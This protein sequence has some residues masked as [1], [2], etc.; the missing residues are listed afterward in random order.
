M[1]IET[2]QSD[3]QPLNRANSCATL[4]VRHSPCPLA[5]G[6]RRAISPRDSCENGG[7]QVSPCRR[8]A[9]SRIGSAES[10]H[11]ATF[12]SNPTLT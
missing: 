5:V 12:L 4:P 1:I 9:P 10:P 3:G 7:Q 8:L 11:T 6:M 2:A